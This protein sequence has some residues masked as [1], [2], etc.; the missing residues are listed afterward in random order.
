ML[1]VCVLNFGKLYFGYV[2]YLWYNLYEICCFIWK[3]FMGCIIS[4]KIFIMMLM[5]EGY[6]LI[7]FGYEVIEKFLE[8]NVKERKD[9]NFL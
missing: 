1:Y 4:Y 7:G 5:C 2:F 3:L 9:F 8:L 6:K